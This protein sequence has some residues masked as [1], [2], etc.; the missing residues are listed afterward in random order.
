MQ[1]WLAQAFH[2][3]K[4]TDPE[5]GNGTRENSGLDISFGMDGVWDRFEEMNAGYLLKTF[6]LLLSGADIIT[7]FRASLALVY[8]KNLLRIIYIQW[9]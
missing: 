4:L 6:G 3:G 1:A 2:L 7:S 9:G 5:T 8:L